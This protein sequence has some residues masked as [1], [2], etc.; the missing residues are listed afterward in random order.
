MRVASVRLGPESCLVEAV[1][2]AHPARSGSLAPRTGNLLPAMGQ[3]PCRS[4]RIA[5]RA[6]EAREFISDK[7]WFICMLRLGEGRKQHLGSKHTFLRVLCTQTSLRHAPTGVPWGSAASNRSVNSAWPIALGTSSASSPPSPYSP[8]PL[9]LARVQPL[10]DPV[11][12]DLPKTD[13]DEEDR[14]RWMAT[15]LVGARGFHQPPP[16][17][18]PRVTWCTIWE[19]RVRVCATRMGGCVRRRLSGRR[20]HE[21]RAS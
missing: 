17:P 6:H 1:T 16:P 4:E 15:T 5:G 21:C 14:D 10:L 3:R 18:P 11:R 19:R 9:L 13:E 12:L 8:P 7:V 2:R 20:Q